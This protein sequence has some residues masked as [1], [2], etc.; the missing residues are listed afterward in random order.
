MKKRK[1]IQKLKELL[2]W[3][4]LKINK[5]LI[6]S[7]VQQT[8]KN[9]N[10][11]FNEILT[12]AN[13]N[14]SISSSNNKIISQ[15]MESTTNEEE[16]SI[17]NNAKF[18]LKS[19]KIVSSESFI[20]KSYYKN[21]NSLSKGKIIKNLEFKKKLEK[22]IK[23]TINKNRNKNSSKFSISSIS[24]DSIKDEFY[25]EKQNYNDKYLSSQ[26]KTKYKNVLL[27]NNNVISNKTNNI[28]TGKNKENIFTHE[29][30]KKYNSSKFFDKENYKIK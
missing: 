14:N 21:I 7:F 27:D 18:Y 25:N 1:K 6:D 11:N 8:L 13:L 2:K 15:L 23:K 26:E 9:Q 29:E 5:N 4:R 16:E 22:I 28:R 3:Q 20:I 30:N 12:T 24:Q 19:L 17:Q 10:S